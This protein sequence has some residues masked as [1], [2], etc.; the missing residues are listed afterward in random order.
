MN[1]PLLML[2]HDGL[3]NG[4]HRGLVLHLHYGDMETILDL[5]VNTRQQKRSVVVVKHD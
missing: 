1:R 2:P 5:E 4:R 3:L